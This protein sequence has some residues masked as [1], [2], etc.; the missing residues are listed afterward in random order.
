[1]FIDR[2]AELAFLNDVITREHPGPGQFVMLYGRRRVGKT[3]LLR[4]WAEQSGLPFTY[5]VAEKDPAPLQR[6]KLFAELL[7][8]LGTVLPVPA[9]ESWA[10]LWRGVAQLTAGRRH[11]LILDELPYAAEADPA[12]LSSLQHAWDQLFQRSQTVIVICGSHVRTMELLLGRQSP[13]FGR[14]TGQW[15]LLP[16][17]FGTLREFLPRWSPEEQ[18][19]AYAI[20]GGIPA[21]LSW[22]NP[23]Q[24]LTTNIKHVML[25]PG[26]LVLAEAAFLLQDEVREPRPYLAVLQALGNGHHTLKEI[27]N[28]SMIATAH[29]SFYLSQLQELRLVE[30]RLPATLTQAEQRRSRM[31][32]YHLSDPFLRFYFRFLAPAAAAGNLSYRSERVLPGIQSGLRAFVGGSA[33]EELARQ[34]ADR[35]A[36]ADT[37]GFLPQAVGSHW[38][39]KVQV[40]VV[41]VDWQNRQLLLGECKWTADPVDR[42][43]VRELIEQKTPLV[44]ADMEASAGDWSIR[45]ALF[46][47][48]G[49]TEAARETL[50]AHGGLLV[51][52]DQ[53]YDDLGAEHG[54]PA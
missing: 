36:A 26:S 41:A 51:D 7:Q 50:A 15:H 9:F 2:A 54:S 17:A 10:E 38:S 37:L 34:W 49:A 3:A 40:D 8:S 24:S 18:V 27:A 28:A 35:P 1:M 32:R 12:M 19:A 47:R 52:L 43:V 31:G 14:M 13:L 21:Y 45:H 53:L 46:A 30:R 16:L 29:L 44:L 11:L 42:K 25:A 39:R 33:W 20:V 6:R 48:A 5:W 22:L 23:R 4:A